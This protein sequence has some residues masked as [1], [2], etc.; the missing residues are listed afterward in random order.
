MQQEKNVDY[1]RD[2]MRISRLYMFIYLYFSLI[3][4]IRIA[5]Q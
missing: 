2:D 3:F 1:D 4:N 5:T